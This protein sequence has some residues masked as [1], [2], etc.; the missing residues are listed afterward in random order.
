[1]QSIHDSI[2]CTRAVQAR[3]HLLFLFVFFSLPFQLSLFFAPRIPGK[4]K[5]SN[6]RCD[7]VP[8]HSGMAFF[9]WPDLPHSRSSWYHFSASTPSNM[10]CASL[11]YTLLLHCTTR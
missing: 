11:L 4:K 3:L 7:I 2:F 8:D 5:K 10:L 6:F 1:M 9:V